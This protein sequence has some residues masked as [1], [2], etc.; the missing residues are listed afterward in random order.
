MSSYTAIAD[1]GDT[2]VELFKDNMKDVDD[3]DSIVLA[4][5][6]EVG[7][8]KV[9]LTVFLYQVIENIHFNNQEMQIKNSTTLK[10]PPIALDLYYMITPHIISSDSFTESTKQAHVTL[11]RVIQILNDNSI[12]TGSVLKGSLAGSN[13]EI[14]I[15][16]TSMSLDDMTKIWT[17]FQGKSFMS[18]ICFIVTPVLIDSSRETTVPRVISKETDYNRILPK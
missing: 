9:L 16:L 13:D 2:L 4:S 10:Q 3:R 5:P 8:K 1:I 18:S 6:G 12:L 14:H 15:I 17:T 11:G 7:D